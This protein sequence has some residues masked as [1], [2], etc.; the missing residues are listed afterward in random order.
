MICFFKKI[1]T[2]DDQIK[3]TQPDNRLIARCSN[4]GKSYDLDGY[5]FSALNDVSCEFPAGKMGFL[6]GPSGCGKTTLLN[7]LG[8]IDKPSSGDIEFLGKNVNKLSEDERADFRNAHIGFIF[9]SFNLI[10]VL[11]VRENV[12]FPLIRRQMPQKERS[13]RAEYYLQS[14]GLK[15]V[16]NRKIAQISGGQRQRVAI[17]RALVTEPDLVI[18]DEPTAN[19]DS[20]TSIEIINLMSQMQQQFKTAFVICSHNE[21]LL[22]PDSYVFRMKDGMLVSEGGREIQ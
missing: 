10:S 14:V 20:V 19:L 12:E 3:I 17:A 5:S 1:M 9:Q 16:I 4:V 18:A 21:H 6:F 2:M 7:L 15:D 13:E 8:L 11:S 22:Q